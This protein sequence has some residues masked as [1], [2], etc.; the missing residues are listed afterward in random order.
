MKILLD[1]H[2]DRDVLLGVYRKTLNAE[3]KL[4]VDVGLQGK[5]DSE[6]LEWAAQNGYILLTKDKATMSTFAYQR[7]QE[8]LEV[9]GVILITRHLSIG[10]IIKNLVLLVECAT[11]EEFKSAFI[12]L[13]FN[14]KV[15]QKHY[16]R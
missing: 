13:L 6:L 9:F 3:M 12:L 2:I 14:K 16:S 15:T 10:E 1:E 11:E 8:G 5:S 7:M 4:A